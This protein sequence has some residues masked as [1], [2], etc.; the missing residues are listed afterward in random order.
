VLER[1][2]IDLREG[3]LDRELDALLRQGRLTPAMREPARK[4][5]ALGE[6]VSAHLAD[7]EEQLDVAAELRALL[8]AVPEYALTDLRERTLYEAPRLVGEMTDERAAK[9]AAE[10]RRLAKLEA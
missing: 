4:L 8:A 7:G 5:L 6:P 10:N 9:L 1:E 3:A 2:L